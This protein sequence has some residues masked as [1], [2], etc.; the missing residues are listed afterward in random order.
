[1]QSLLTMMMSTEQ[2]GAKQEAAGDSQ[3]QRVSAYSWSVLLKSV[4]STVQLNR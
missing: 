2:V 3:A 4:L 1:M